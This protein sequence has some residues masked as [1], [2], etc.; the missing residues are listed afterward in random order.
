MNYLNT[1][2]GFVKYVGYTGNLLVSQRHYGIKVD[3]ESTL[4][5]Q[6]VNMLKNYLWA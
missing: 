5:G 4:C 6:N 2:S 3:A 1:E